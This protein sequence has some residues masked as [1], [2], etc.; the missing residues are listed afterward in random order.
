MTQR[1][2]LL[3][4]FVL[5]MGIGTRS[6]GGVLDFHGQA[7]SWFT[8]ADVD[9]L[10][11]EFG[12][13]YI[14]SLVAETHF[15]G[16]HLIDAEISFD[17]NGRLSQI[18]SF[19]D[20]ESDYDIDPYRLWLRLSSRQYEIRGGLQKINF[21]SATVFRPLMWFDQIDVRDPLRITEGVYAM[22]LR[23]YFLNNTNIWVWGLY[24]NHEVKG[25]EI[26]STDSGAVEYGGRVQIPILAGE[27]A[28]TYHHRDFTIG[29]LYLDALPENR[30]GVDGK[31]DIGVGA[32]IE[33]ALVYQDLG[34][35]PD[36]LVQQYPLFQLEYRRFLN[37]G[38]DYTFD[39]GNGIYLLFEHLYNDLSDEVFGDTREKRQLSA[40]LIR[41]PV[42]TVDELSVA[43]YYDW[44]TGELYRYAKWTRIYDRWMINLS[45]F[46][47]PESAISGS[48]NLENPYA[49]TG[50]QLT[51]AYNH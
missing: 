46:W 32:W 22:L 25:W 37:A 9:S 5:V 49:G 33:A 38:I 34:A 21:G 41:Y 3:S 28:L 2:S 40:T 26:Y 16:T 17:I 47:S 10:Q 11:A 7:S 8:L 19:E 23:Y 48:R 6:T 20:Y 45:C 29:E 44:E 39:I 50:L 51:V 27:F 1:L 31:W 14:P 15:A 24:G 30:L 12:V 18:R 4:I 36:F 43:V 42:G 35:L 13:R